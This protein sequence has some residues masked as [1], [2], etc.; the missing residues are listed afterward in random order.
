MDTQPSKPA[1]ITTRRTL[2]LLWSH[3]VP[4]NGLMV[5]GVLALIGGSL[6]GL[7]QPLATGRLLE[8][9]DDSVML[10]NAILLLV[11]VLAATLLFSFFGNY[12]LAR[13]TETVV[14]GARGRLA[15]R[16][17]SL[18]V[19]T[20]HRENPGELTT[21]ITSDSSMIRVVAVTCVAQLVT[22]IV[23]IVGS[24][25]IM[26]TLNPLLLIITLAFLVMPA[27]AL[28]FTVPLVRVWAKRTQIAMGLLGRDL[29][30]IFGTHSTVKAN[31]AEETEADLLIDRISD[32][33]DKGAK[34]GFWRSLNTT[35]SMGIVQVSYLSVLAVG[36][37]MVSQDR[38][39]LIHI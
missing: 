2:R 36:G 4:V 6:S 28:L 32:V 10:R 23:S 29:E 11:G 19:G 15:R 18:S 25:I 38:L 35:L 13:A 14:A 20:M 30:R 7:L 8:M 3:M 37:V 27:G 9:L 24:V 39:S 1:T 26:A 5:V 22:G 16:V 34:S 31:G 33:R 12:L 17:L 21:R